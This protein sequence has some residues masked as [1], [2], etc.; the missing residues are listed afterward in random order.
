MSLSRRAVLGVAAAGTVSTAFSAPGHAQSS[1]L[2]AAI[3]AAVQE[4]LDAGACPGIAV[5]IGRG[6]APLF[7]RDYGMANLETGTAVDSRSIFR[8]ASLTKQFAAVAAVKLASLGKLDLDDAVSNYLPDFDSVERFSIREL[9][10]HTAGLS[11][12]SSP[13]P[14]AD[15]NSMQSSLAL[16]QEIANQPKVF[17]F[18]PGT[19][20]LYSNANYKVLGA[21]IE[22]VMGQPLAAA[23][24]ELV[25]RPLG[26]R[27]L[28]FDR[29]STVLPG[30]VNGYAPV[31]D[32][33]S[34]DNAPLIEIANAG[35]SGAMR[36]T[37]ADLIR[38][39]HLLLSGAVL[40]QERLRELLTP[41]RLRDGRPSGANRF[42]ERDAAY[43]ETQYALGLL[44]PP[45]S[46]LGQVI[47]HYGY[48]EGFS[49]C[50]ETYVEKGVTMA[51][52]CNGEAGPLLPFRGIRR[53]VVA[54][55]SA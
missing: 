28:A 47:Q 19:A 38:W 42:S 23:M 41:G 8:I 10:T 18:P 55:M 20:W 1:A 21:V 48:I 5:A 22:Q 36:G 3:D 4:A 52:L 45:P 25:F 12:E 16:A 24:E 35:A 13:S 15:P 2:G 53:A 50:L 26:L 7:V 33:S 31:G 49:A 30:R 40:D 6:G 29:S 32:G 17:D 27:S 51:V 39:H 37:A 11:D 54:D 46:G 43:G 34:F 9:M 44:V 14:S